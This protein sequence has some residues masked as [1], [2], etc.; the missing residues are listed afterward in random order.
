MK[1]ITWIGFTGLALSI[2]LA[3]PLFS[4]DTPQVRLR[5]KPLTLMGTAITPGQ[6]LPRLSLPDS[7]M[8][9]VDL[10]AF[11]GKVTI[12]SVVPS[13]DTRVCEKQT[14]I[15]SEENGGLDA[16]VRLVTVSRDLPF[17]QKRFAQEAKINNVLFLSDYRDAGFGTASGLLI[18]E[19]RLLTRAVMVLD[20]AGIIRHLEIVPD[21]GQLPDMK[22]AFAVAGSL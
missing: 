6:A 8:K 22:K 2:L 7:R 18:Q 20:K 14:H 4:K 21:L 3:N 16:T 11:K 5:G 19:N 13:I 15:L 9:P 10:S 1:R 17:A 12:V